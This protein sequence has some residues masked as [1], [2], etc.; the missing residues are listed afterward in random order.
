M[1]SNICQDAA[2]CELTTDGGFCIAASVFWLIAGAT[3]LILK[4]RDRLIPASTAT[5]VYAGAPAVAALSTPVQET[6]AIIQNK[7]GSTTKTIYRTTTNS[8]GTPTVTQITEVE[9]VV[10]IIS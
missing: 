7:D 6:I 3:A 10:T 8:N 5:A 4:P 9:P 1:A 2:Q